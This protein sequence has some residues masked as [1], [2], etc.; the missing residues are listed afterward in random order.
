MAPLASSLSS[1]LSLF[2]STLS[3]S[4]T[5]R[6]VSDSVLVSL[7]R[8]RIV[9]PHTPS[10]APSLTRPSRLNAS[11]RLFSRFPIPPLIAPP[12][13]IE[14]LVSS[15]KSATVLAR[16]FLL[17]S[18]FPEARRQP[19][20]YPNLPILSSSLPVC[21]PPFKFLH[22]QFSVCS[23]PP[24]IFFSLFF[25]SRL[26]PPCVFFFQLPSVLSLSQPLSSL[27]HLSHSLPAPLPK[28][29]YVSLSLLFCSLPPPYASRSRALSFLSSQAP[30]FP[31]LTKKKREKKERERL[32]E[33]N[34]TTSH[35]ASGQGKAS[36]ASSSRQ[37]R[38]MR[39]RTNVRSDI[40]RQ[41]QLGVGRSVS[42]L[43]GSSFPRSDRTSERASDPLG[44]GLERPSCE[45]SHAMDRKGLQKSKGGEKKGK[46][47]PE[48]GGG[49]RRKGDQ[50]E[51]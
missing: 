21:F 28:P 17:P 3:S 43:A 51:R 37:A 16:P 11:S 1:R 40:R 47:G 38:R 13:L 20:D 27:S 9:S 34:N 24:S 19:M 32:R 42:F 41:P 8:T 4:S 6:S 30:F 48:S 44:G 26:P 14:S 10:S 2:V 15:I 31:P 39:A 46:K 5:A 45:Q 33:K 23:P 12:A 36:L 22:L 29:Y 35:H 25:F 49:G 7:I 18:L 50:M